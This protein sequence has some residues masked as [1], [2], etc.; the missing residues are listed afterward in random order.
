MANREPPHIVVVDDELRSLELLQRTL[1]PL[2]NVQAFG[3]AESAWRSIANAPPVLV[4]SDQRM[5]GTTGA[6]L[7]TRVAELALP[8]GRILLTGYSDLAATVEAINRGR[9]H[10]YIEKP[11]SPEQLLASARTVLENTHLERTNRRLLAE[12]VEKNSM[13]EGTLRSLN[14]AQ[15][16]VLRGE[17]LAA[18]G[19]LIAM[20]VHDFR[21]PLTIVRSAVAELKERADELSREERAE[22]ATTALDETQRMMR[23]CSHLLDSVRPSENGGARERVGLD[24][25]LLDVVASVAESAGQA[26]VTVETQLDAPVELELDGDRMRRAVLNLLQNAIEA[27]PDGGTLTVSTQREE[28][29]VLLRI[30]DTGAGIPEELA[31]RLF[32][33]FATSG[34]RGGSGL[35]LAVVKKVVDDHGGTVTA[36]KA[37][38]GG[39]CFDVRLPLTATRTGIAP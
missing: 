21:S 11:W 1:R 28:G 39:A 5:P 17:R 12:L 19:R 30:Q 2:G 33:P 14:E 26:G 22:L 24:D 38:G 16:Q 25:W 18:I 3:D 29:V 37:E 32:E 9:V 35:G 23:M 10:A 7:L 15:G 34:K 4:I 27:M 13:L 8:I 31:G 6:Q 20:V 36:G